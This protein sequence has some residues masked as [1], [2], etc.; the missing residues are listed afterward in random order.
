MGAFLRNVHLTASLLSYRPV[1][2]LHCLLGKSMLFSRLHM[3]RDLAPYH[4]CPFPPISHTGGISA[5]KALF[6]IAVILH[7]RF[8]PCGKL[9][10]PLAPR[11]AE[12]FLSRYCNTCAYFNSYMYHTALFVSKFVSP[13]GGGFL[14]VKSQVTVHLGTPKFSLNVC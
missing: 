7:L 3:P 2:T 1:R 9:S 13:P 4:V 6:H 12:P 10:A 8:L 14:E 5:K 11:W